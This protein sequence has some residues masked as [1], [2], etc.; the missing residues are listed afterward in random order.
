MI[1]LGFGI[2]LILSVQILPAAFNSTDGYINVPIAKQYRM[3]EIQ[4]GISNAYNGS[5]AIQDDETDRYE[6]DFKS[7]FSINSQNQKYNKG[8]KS[9]SSRSKIRLL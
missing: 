6:M 8:L 3:S 9:Y 2:I 5:A 7:V 1:R 4:F